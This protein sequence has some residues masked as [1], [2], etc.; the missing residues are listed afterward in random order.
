MKSKKPGVPFLTAIREVVT[1]RSTCWSYGANLS[2][3]VV[4]GDALHYPTTQ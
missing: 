1:V 2:R 4:I 3:H